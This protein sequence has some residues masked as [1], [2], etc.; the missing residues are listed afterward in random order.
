M[1]DPC[2]LFE[3]P[4]LV[5]MRSQVKSL[6]IQYACHFT[7]N[8]ATCK[9]KIRH[10]LSFIDHDVT[11]YPTMLTDLLEGFYKSTAQFMA[12]FK[13]AVDQKGIQLIFLRPWLNICQSNILLHFHQ[14]LNKYLRPDYLYQQL[15]KSAVWLPTCFSQAAPTVHLTPTAGGKTATLS[16]GRHWQGTPESGSPTFGDTFKKHQPDKREALRWRDTGGERAP[17][18]PALWRT[19]RAATRRGVN[20]FRLWEEGIWS[21]ERAR[22][23]AARR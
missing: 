2:R 4:I 10:I 11:L 13:K 19:N 18:R 14:S 3:I 22:S 23:W 20:P 6:C 8:E 15:L 17:P 5:H 1:S 21:R 9:N 16:Q 12:Q 7:Y